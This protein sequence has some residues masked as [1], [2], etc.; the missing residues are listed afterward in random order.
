MV[1][2][3][4]AALLA[5]EGKGGEGEPCKSDSI[6][7]PS[8]CD[9]D[10]ICNDAVQ[11]ATCERAMSRSEGQRCNADQLCASGLWCDQLVKQCRPFLKEGDPCSNPFSCGPERTCQ[12]D[13]ATMTITCQPPRSSSDGGADSR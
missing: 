13:L 7:G 6:L 5:C 1:L 4:A 10:L 8:Y 11:P 9:G 3:A 2:A 12:K